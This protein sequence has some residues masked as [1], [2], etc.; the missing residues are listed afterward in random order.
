M[1]HLD[2][3][4]LQHNFLMLFWLSTPH[5]ALLMTVQIHLGKQG[6]SLEAFQEETP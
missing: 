4:Q 3:P 2:L 1:Q 5:F 6:T